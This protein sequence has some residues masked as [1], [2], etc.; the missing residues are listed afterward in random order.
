MSA[1]NTLTIIRK[2]NMNSVGSTGAS[3]P[4]F[5]AWLDTVRIRNALTFLALKVRA[6]NLAILCPA[7]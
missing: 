5:A 1:K 3:T 2:R 4:L 7:T 6:V